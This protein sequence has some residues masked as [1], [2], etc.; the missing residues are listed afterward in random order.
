MFPFREALRSSS[1]L[2]FEFN[3][4]I[5]MGCMREK[6]VC[7]GK[8]DRIFT[9]WRP[10]VG[11]RDTHAS[12][13]WFKLY[14][15]RMRNLSK[16]PMPGLSCESKAGHGCYKKSTKSILLSV[17]NAMERCRLWQLSRTP[18]SLPGL[19]TGQSSKNGG[20]QCLSALVSLQNWHGRRDTTP[21]RS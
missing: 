17:Q 10:M 4:R 9:A 15:K 7:S 2:N 11:K 13:P 8:N 12:P 14:N 1:R 21:K 3:R 16:P 19:L 18:R 6:S 5:F 20:S